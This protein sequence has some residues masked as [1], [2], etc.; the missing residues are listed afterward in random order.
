MNG[1]GVN[2]V[3]NATGNNYR[4]TYYAMQL[5]NNCILSSELQTSWTGMPTWNFTSMNS[6]PS[7]SNLP[8]LSSFLYTDGSTKRCAVYYNDDETSH[9]IT[10]AGQNAPSGSVT[11][12][13]YYSANLNDDNETTVKVPPPAYKNIKW[14]GSLSLNPHS[15]TTI[16]Y[17]TDAP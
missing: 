9:N 3:T 16:A 8:L 13:S 1:F 14:T 5:V 17:T 4:P 6:V 11:V 7:A 10:I 12:G 2:S 15:I